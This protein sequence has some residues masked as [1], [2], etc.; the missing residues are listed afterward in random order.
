MTDSGSP[1]AP[2]VRDENPQE[3]GGC[4]VTSNDYR[5]NRPAFEHYALLDAERER[6]PF[7]W[8]DS[9][10]HPFWMVTRYEHVHEALRMPEVFSNEVINALNPYMAVRFLPQNLDPPEHTRVRKV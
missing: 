2:S 8:N 3:R 9:T 6:A 10:R 5:G 1:P 4:P 7:L